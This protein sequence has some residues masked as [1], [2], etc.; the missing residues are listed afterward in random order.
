MSGC[1]STL[2]LAIAAFLVST[3]PTCS[4]QESRYAGQYEGLSF[5]PYKHI[6][7]PVDITQPQGEC[8][9][10]DNVTCPLYVAYMTSFGG[11][12]TSSGALPGVQIALDQINDNTDILPGYSLHYLLMDSQV[13]Y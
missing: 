8:T 7:P 6:Y 9:P 1:C 3:A 13:L 11:S 12:F 5:G 2:V 10:S 4:S